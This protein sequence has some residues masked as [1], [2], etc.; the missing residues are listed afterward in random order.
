GRARRRR[1]RPAHA[2]P[3]VRPRPLGLRPQPERGD[4]RDAEAAAAGGVRPRR[5]A[6]R[7]VSPPTAGLTGFYPARERPPSQP[8]PRG[9]GGGRNANLAL[10]PVLELKPGDAAKM[11]HISGYEGQAPDHRR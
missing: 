6:L 8:P 10:E 11:A 5:R 7:S 9:A 4:V 1:P 2:A 3:C